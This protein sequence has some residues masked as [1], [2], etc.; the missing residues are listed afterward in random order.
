MQLTQEQTR[1]INNFLEGIGVEY[2]DIRFEMVDHIASEIES[3]IE[4]TDA[5]FENNR[6]QTPFIKYMLSR[7]TALL[8]E[9]NSII[10]RK[11]LADYLS[12]AKNSIFQLSKPIHCLT[13]GL[14][15]VIALYLI[16]YKPEIS[17]YFLFTCLFI[18]MTY[19]A[20]NTIS[21]MKKHQLIK[22]V[23][24]YNSITI[25]LTLS[26]VHTASIINFNQRP[27]FSFY[28][29]YIHL[30]VIIVIYI[31]HQSFISKQKTIQTKYKYFVE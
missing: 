8:L 26:I 19:F 7:K 13:V 18:E 20:Y 12:I 10:K 9:Y 16:N 11:F 25:F 28:F 30:I 23:N 3:N 6:L 4:N 27:V 17:E 24:A 5:F 1:R 22:I 2:I 14:F 21:F 15:L 29:S 31:I